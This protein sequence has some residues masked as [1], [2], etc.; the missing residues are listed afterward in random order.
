[1]TVV[2]RINVMINLKMENSVAVQSETR[3]TPDCLVHM[4]QL[5]VARPGA[6]R[7]AARGKGWL[8]SSRKDG[9]P[10]GGLSGYVS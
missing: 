8:E 1:M 6:G 9:P 3:D 4:W 5:C 10:K 7:P 2:I